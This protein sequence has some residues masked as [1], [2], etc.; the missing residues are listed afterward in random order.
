M[1]EAIKQLLQHTIVYKYQLPYNGIDKTSL[2]TEPD[3]CFSVSS[4]AA[5]SKL[6]YNGIV[7]YALGEKHVDFVSVK[8]LCPGCV[9]KPMLLKIQN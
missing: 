5:L 7:E 9:S 6:I 1:R 2:S 8:L 4:N 3:R